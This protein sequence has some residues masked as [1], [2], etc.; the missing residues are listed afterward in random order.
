MEVICNGTKITAISIEF[1]DIGDLQKVEETLAE[2]AN[3]LFLFVSV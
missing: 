1:R 3:F 2:T